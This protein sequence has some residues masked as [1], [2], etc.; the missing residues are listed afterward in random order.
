LITGSGDS[1]V[2]DVGGQRPKGGA[3]LPLEPLPVTDEH[4]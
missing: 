1:D 3:G 4:Q 2:D